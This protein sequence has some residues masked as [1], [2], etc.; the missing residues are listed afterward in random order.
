MSAFFIRCIFKLVA[1]IVIS[2]RYEWKAV[3]KKTISFMYTK[4][5]DSSTGGAFALTNKFRFYWRRHYIYTSFAFPWA[6]RAAPRTKFKK[7]LILVILF[8]EFIIITHFDFSRFEQFLTRSQPRFVSLCL[9]T[10]KKVLIFIP[11]DCISQL[12]GGNFMSG[13]N[14][15]ICYLPFSQNHCN[16]LLSYI[17]M[18]VRTISWLQNNF[19]SNNHLLVSFCFNDFV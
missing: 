14:F 12:F 13:L 5:R 2:N 17:L 15:V 8:V 19:R 16:F 11:L 18:A 1:D 10:F 3:A 9:R 7:K 6:Q 4:I